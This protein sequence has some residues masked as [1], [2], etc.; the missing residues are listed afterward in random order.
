MKNYR[1]NAVMAGVLYFLGTVFGVASTVVGGEVISSIVTN[2]P[3]SGM[4]LLD[5]VASN[6]FQITGG[7]FLILMMGISLVAM[8]IFL[9]P[10]FKKDS[11]V[12]ATGMLLFR[13]ALEGAYYFISTLGFLIL[14]LLANEYVVTGADSTPLQSM[15]NVIYQFQSQIGSVGTIFFLIG[16]TCL[17]I[18]FYRTRL[19][20]RWLS[21]WGLI[22]VVPYMTYAL[23]HFFHI[24]IG[25]GFYLQMVLAPQEMVMALWLIIKGFDHAAINKLMAE[26]C[27]S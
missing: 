21:V 9:Y 25:L 4:D 19:I 2:K 1:M 10:I 3:L 8:T 12:L 20:P 22:G 13:G 16:A 6:S 26:R 5:L 14:V 23:L 17:Y 15:G 11:E 24:N 18:S 27:Y 7:S